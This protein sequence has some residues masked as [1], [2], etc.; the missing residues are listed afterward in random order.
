MKTVRQT[1]KKKSGAGAVWRIVLIVCLIAASLGL[2]GAAWYL[3]PYT[4]KTMDLSLLDIPE[5]NRPSALYAYAPDQR[6]ERQGELHAAPRSTIGDRRL[7]IRVSYEEIP[8]DLIHAF[9]AIEDKRF[10]EHDGVD[11]LRTLRAA[12]GYLTGSASFGGSTITQQLVKNLTGEDDHSVDRK[13]TEIFRAMDLEE[14]VSKEDILE[15]YLNVINLSRGCY[16][17]GAAAKRYFS[18][19]V[20]ELTLSECASIAAITNN[21]TRYDPLTHPEDNYARRNVILGEMAAQGYITE[22]ERDEAVASALEVHPSAPSQPGAVTSW[23]TDLV[24]SDVIRDLQERLGYS[25]A[26]ASN[27]V[28]SGG[29]VIETAMDEELQGVVEAYYEDEGNFPAGTSGHPQS[30][31]ILLDPYTG[32]ILAVAGAVGVKNAHRLQN[33]A[34]DTRRPAGSCI[35]PLTVYAP[36]LHR[37]LIN[38][39]T[40]YED[41]PLADREGSPW[42]ANADGLYRGRVSVGQAVAHSLNPVSVRILEQVGAEYA[43]SFAEERLRLHSLLGRDGQSLN[44]MTVSSLALG[45]QTRGVTARELTA[46]YT[47][48]ADGVYRAP[49]SYHRVLDAGGR[50]LLENPARADRVLSSENAAIMTRLLMGVTEEGPAAR[51]VTKLRERGISCAGKTG[52]TQ[53]NCDRWF[54][55]YTPRLLAGVWMGYDYPAE[56]KG[57]YGNP[58]VGIWDD[59][60]DTWEAIYRGAPEK[61]EFDTP[62][63]LVKLEFCPLSGNLANPYCKDPVYGRHTEMGWFIRGQEPAEL[64]REHEEPPIQIIPDDPSDPLRIPVLPEDLAPGETEPSSPRRDGLPKSRRRFADFFERLPRPFRGL[65]S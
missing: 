9:V 36:A 64:C 8:P 57:I 45:Q 53:N 32:D 14:Q 38:W 44:D 47:V 63:T 12:L 21:P 51:G 33:Y 16:G 61:K 28:Y 34:T 59:L 23:Y 26:A 46:A 5:V 25:Y 55:G 42:P 60:M 43:F 65:G 40:L 22:E 35:K 6:A 17:V 62:D 37:G 52:T 58:C 30:A 50:V 13:L 48:F 41:E 56:L 2:G 49:I 10:W 18:K 27:M 4:K 20:S 54:I 19:S 24:V 31:V 29:L 1:K 3:A 7:R 15:A 39:A 11:L